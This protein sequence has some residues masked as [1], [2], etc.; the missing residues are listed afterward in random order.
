VAGRQKLFNPGGLKSEFHEFRLSAPVALL[1]VLVVLAVGDYVG[2]N[3]TLLLLVLG[4]PLFMAGIAL[5]HGVVA[6]RELAG[7]WLIGFYIALIILTPW[8]FWF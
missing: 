8:L 5:V 7:G 3:P 4:L 2:L 6:K 1:A